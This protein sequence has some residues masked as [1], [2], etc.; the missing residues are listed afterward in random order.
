MYVLRAV[1]DTKCPSPRK[2]A[3]CHPPWHLGVCAGPGSSRASARAQ[4][5]R[6]AGCPASGRGSRR[7]A[8]RCRLGLTPLFLRPVSSTS[9]TSPVSSWRGTGWLRAEEAPP[10]RGTACAGLSSGVERVLDP[11]F[12]IV[13]SFLD[14]ADGQGS[15]LG[16][17]K[18]ACK[19]RWMFRKG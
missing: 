18:Q 14:T 15:L 2:P 6:L 8:R 10:W 16:V 5:Q 13:S 3:L 19:S 17:L 12:S 11:S 9:R 1:G 4:W 7:A